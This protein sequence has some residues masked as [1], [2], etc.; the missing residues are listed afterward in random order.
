MTRKFKL[1]GLVNSANDYKKW[2][3]I[4]GLVNNMVETSMINNFAS[5]NPLPEPRFLLPLL[6]KE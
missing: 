6:Q 2:K 4:G 1:N 5:I 3:E